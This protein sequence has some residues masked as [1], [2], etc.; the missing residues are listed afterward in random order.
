MRVAQASMSIATAAFAGLALTMPAKAVEIQ[1]LLGRWSSPDLDECGEPDNSEGAPLSIRLES[2]EVWI[3]NYGW[4]CS[5]PVGDWRADG[6]FLTGSARACG[7]EGGDDPFDQDFRLGLDKQ[8]R[9]LMVDGET[10][11]TL[12]RCPAA[13]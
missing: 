2:G 10:T 1:Q 5:V 7:Q 9:L 13:P 8:D 11:T 12:R 3:G 6:D 4:L